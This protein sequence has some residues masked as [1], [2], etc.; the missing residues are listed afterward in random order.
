MLTLCP[1]GDGTTTQHWFETIIPGILLHQVFEFRLYPV[2]SPHATG[3]NPEHSLHVKQSHDV[4]HPSNSTGFKCKF[5]SC[6][7]ETA[8]LFPWVR[9]YQVLTQIVTSSLQIYFHFRPFMGFKPPLQTSRRKHGT[10]SSIRL[11]TPNMT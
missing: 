7:Y 5:H 8:I 4:T 2:H 3:L 1:G 10:C 6:S 9:R 11:P